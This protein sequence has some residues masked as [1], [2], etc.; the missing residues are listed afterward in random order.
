VQ[1]TRRRIISAAVELIEREGVDAALMRRLATELGCG[2]IGLYG[3]V[4][5]QSAL[6]DDVAEEVLASCHLNDL[7][8]D[9]WAE[10]LRAQAR[11]F[12]R[13]LRA[14]PRCTQLLVTRPPRTASGYRP[15]ESALAALQAAGFS[16]QSAASIV[17]TALCI[18]LGATMSGAD[19]ADA[20]FDSGLD[21]LIAAAAA[22]LRPAGV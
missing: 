10:Q 1:L 4:P 19:P 2:L 12:L 6:L 20:D 5:S 8:A 21:L 16:A 13:S 18:A 3:H 9:D 14:H 22:A 7:P 15:A 11:T 17:R